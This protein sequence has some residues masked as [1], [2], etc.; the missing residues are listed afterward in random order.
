MSTAFSIIYLLLY[1][2][3]EAVTAFVDLHLG[4][5]LQAL[6]VVATLLV[7][8]FRPFPDEE[9]IVVGIALLA[10]QRL[11]SVTL[12][13]SRMQEFT[14]YGVIGIPILIGV[15]LAQR[16]YF[17]AWLPKA[18]RGHLTLEAN[19][20]LGLLGV[21]AAMIAYIV[22][23][24]QLLQ[25][26]LS[27]P[28]FFLDFVSVIVFAGMLQ[29]LLYRGYLQRVVRR[30]I[31]AWSILFVSVAFAGSTFGVY[32]LPFTLAAFGMSCVYGFIYDRYRALVALLVAHGLFAF[33]YLI[34]FPVIFR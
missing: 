17:G 22:Y 9:A 19:I 11:F 4:I 27:T 24:P 31:G 1:C 33:F 29:E 8:L 28:G 2:L 5:G 23:Q 20:I 21:P 3:A 12:P 32:S 15:L 16:L 26:A 6:I 30:K 14:W 13:S 34:V 10:L 25:S 7:I 18:M